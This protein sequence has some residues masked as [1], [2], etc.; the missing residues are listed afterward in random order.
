MLLSKETTIEP[1]M[2]TATQIKTLFRPYSLL[3]DAINS[4]AIRSSPPTRGVPYVDVV[5]ANACI[6]FLQLNVI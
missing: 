1:Y 3:R 5:D 4:V 2:I 6:A